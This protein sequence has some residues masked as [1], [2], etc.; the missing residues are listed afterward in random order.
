[1]QITV[2]DSNH[3]NAELDLNV[4]VLDQTDF[5]DFWDGT[6]TSFVYDGVTWNIQKSSS[7]QYRTIRLQ[8]AHNVQAVGELDLILEHAGL[9]GQISGSDSVQTLYEQ[10]GTSYLRKDN[11]GT[12]YP[13]FTYSYT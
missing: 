4:N 1:M 6:A 5:N 3:Q 12:S 8:A 9:P 2:Y 7:G 13:Y 11:T 10:P